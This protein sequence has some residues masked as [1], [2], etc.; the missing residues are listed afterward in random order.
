[1][2]LIYH[3]IPKS[4]FMENKKNTS[5]I[6]IFIEGIPTEKT[7]IEERRKLIESY[8]EKFWRREHYIYN[9]FLRA[10][11]YIKKN[12]S[13]K[14]VKAIAPRK[15]QSTYAIKHL[16]QVVKSAKPLTETIE[17]DTP[18]TGTQ[19]KNGYKRMLILYYKFTNDKY[20]YLNFTVK[21]TIGINSVGKYIQYSV[22]KVEKE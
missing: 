20:E 10:N 18:K 19:V 1:M 14:K 6:P 11:V 17:Y 7:L 8:Y 15:W 3:Y 9:E 4:K 16:E 13:D 22:N 2:Y 5:I 12:E 21:L